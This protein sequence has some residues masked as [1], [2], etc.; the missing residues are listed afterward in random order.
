MSSSAAKDLVEYVVTSL[1]DH[2]DQVQVTE[3][4][5]G[6][7]MVI[8]VR[9]AESDMGRVIGRRGSVV[10]SMRTLLQVPGYRKGK[11]IQLEI[12]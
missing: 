7:T 4:D 1:V 12:V 9:V 5:E 3:I 6:Q 10:N 11:R 8:E 2:P